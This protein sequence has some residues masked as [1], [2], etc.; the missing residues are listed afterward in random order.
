MVVVPG[1]L[2]S[3]VALPWRGGSRGP[4]V[5]LPL[6]SARLTKLCRFSGHRKTSMLW[7]QRQLSGSLQSVTVTR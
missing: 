7:L 5:A 2:D 1:G 3:G 6:T 4:P